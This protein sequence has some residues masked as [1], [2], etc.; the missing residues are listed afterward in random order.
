ME[1][2]ASKM[3][4]PNPRVEI[5]QQ[6]F[7]PSTGVVTTQPSACRH[8]MGKRKV[9]SAEERGVVIVAEVVRQ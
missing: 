7:N 2:S 4:S 1:A 3:T 6:G 5:L 9:G 8:A